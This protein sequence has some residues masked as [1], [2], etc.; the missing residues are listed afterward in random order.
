MG[1]KLYGAVF[2]D[3]LAIT[4]VRCSKKDSQNALIERLSWKNCFDMQFSPTMR[5]LQK[6]GWKICE[7]ELSIKE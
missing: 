7:L 2:K 3:E 1:M 6:D 4:T 5:E